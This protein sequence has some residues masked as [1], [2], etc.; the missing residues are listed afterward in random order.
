AHIRSDRRAWPL[1]LLEI[2]CL[3]VFCSAPGFREA[4]RPCAFDP[5]RQKEGGHGMFHNGAGPENV[6]SFRYIIDTAAVSL[7]DSGI[8][9]RQKGCVGRPEF[10]LLFQ[11]GTASRKPSV[12]DLR[13]IA[14]PHLALRRL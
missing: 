2:I 4:R 3:R 1:P 10:F 6:L 14:I 13:A 8:S 5:V 11:S 9:A 7:L 12:L